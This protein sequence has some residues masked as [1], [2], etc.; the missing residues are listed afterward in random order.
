MC[1]WKI[2][3]FEVSY[4]DQKVR[5]L[6]SKPSKSRTRASPSAVSNCGECG[7]GI[8]HENYAVLRR[9]NFPTTVD[10]LR[11]VC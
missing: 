4:S 3:K 2:G 8:M 5:W 10:L 6:S 11:L 7:F 1:F 9:A